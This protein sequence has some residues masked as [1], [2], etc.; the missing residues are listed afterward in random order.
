[1]G[2][3]PGWV[4]SLEESTGLS[5]GLWPSGLYRVVGDGEDP[6]ESRPDDDAVWVTD[7]P[8]SFSHVPGAW[9]LPD[10]GSVVP[11]RLV[12]AVRQAA[13]RAGVHFVTGVPVRRVGADGVEL[14]GG[15]DLSGKPILCAGAWTGKVEG[16]PTL[17][18]HPGRGQVMEL[19]REGIQLSRFKGLGEMNSEQLWETTM[20]PERR[21]LQ[22]VTMDDA[23]SAEEIFSTLMGD[24]VEPRREFIERNARSVA[25]LDI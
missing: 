1:L 13:E 20:D 8:H 3:Y 2:L 19:A 15:G 7:L 25:N 9:W 12:V 10:E 22:R 14:D 5:C 24:R 16:I 23:A 21:I 18:I 4:Q 17:P 11:P 6:A